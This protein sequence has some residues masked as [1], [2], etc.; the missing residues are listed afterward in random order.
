MR[1][2]AET[3]P[4]WMLHAVHSCAE[5]RIKITETKLAEQVNSQ[6]TLGQLTTSLQPTVHPDLISATTWSRARSLS[7]P[8]CACRTYRPNVGRNLRCHCHVWIVPKLCGNKSRDGPRLKNLT[9]CSGQQWEA[10]YDLGCYFQTLDHV[11]KLSDLLRDCWKFDLQL[12][13]KLLRPESEFSATESHAQHLIA[14]PT[15]QV[16]MPRK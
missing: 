14:V 9:L 3:Y 5:M 8:G 12:G 16:N 4:C 6:C 7:P 15:E 2:N 10:K 11:T 13:Q 1:R